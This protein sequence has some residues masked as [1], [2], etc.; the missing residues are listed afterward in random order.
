MALTLISVWA[1]MECRYADSQNMT[2]LRA[3]V[4]FTI[5]VTVYNI[6]AV[7]MCVTLTLTFKMGQGKM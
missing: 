2:Y 1:L 5:F 6:F 4:Q 7:E 3:I